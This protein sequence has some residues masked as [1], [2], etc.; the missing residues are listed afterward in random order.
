MSHPH[1][2]E[3][4]HV[5]FKTHLDVGFTDYARNVVERYFTDYIPRAVTLARE[6]REAQ[7]PRRF[8][9]TTGSWLIYEYLEQAKQD[10]RREME[11]AILE[12]DITWH[13]MPFTVHSENMDPALF[14][15]G[16]SLSSELDRRFGKKTIAAKM[17]DVPGHTRAIVPLLAEAGVRFL[18]I[19][20]NA[21]STPPDVPPVF[22]WQAPSGAEIAVMY[23][24]GSYGDLMTLPDLPDAIAFAHTNDNLGP[25]SKEELE[26]AFGKIQE[27]FKDASVQA[28]TLD[29]FAQSLETIWDR[30]PVIT[31]EIGDTWIHGVG[32]DPAKISRYRALLRLRRTWQEHGIPADKLHDFHRKLLLIPEHTWGMDVK[33]YL[34]DWENYTNAEFLAVRSQENY[35]TIEASWQEQRD[36][37]HAALDGLND[38]NL[39][40]E[41]EAALS[42]VQP[43]RPDVAPFSPIE[44]LAAPQVTDHFIFTLDPQRGFINHLERTPYAEKS[45]PRQWASPDFPLA[46]F[47]YEAFSASD[48]QRFYRQYI[49]NK[50]QTSFWAKPDFTKPGMENAST[51]HK[52][53]YPTLTWAGMCQSPQSQKYLLRCTM[54]EESW[55]R[56]GAPRELTLEITFPRS[57]PVIEFRLQWFDKTACRIAEAL[58]FSFIP[59]VRQPRSWR[60][61]KLGEWISPLEVI[62]DGNCKL[63]AVGQG[64]R[65][66]EAKTCIE[67]ESLDAPLV[68]PGQPSLLDFNNRQPNLRGGM[69]FNLFNNVWGTNFPMWYE[70]DAMLR[71]RLRFKD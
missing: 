12:G 16:L 10:A 61:E 50:R 26:A 1:S 65:C 53:F 25:Q 69:H 44:N 22:R 60:M 58:W 47:R 46:L 64:V 24:K 41:A 55:Q 67:I 42:E 62:R 36:Y 32:T 34:W 5:I 66:Q 20:V 31:Q 35:R 40:S 3:R 21:A 56:Y 15:F 7:S 4:I 54:P 45:R 6:L 39:R 43:A 29:A 70:E 49:Q 28:S 30:L 71:F 57:E 48:Y 52:V 23:H 18:H 38:P 17:T 68:A 59:R 9:W 33:T 11:Q 14:R 13:A 19:G 8:I 37:L 27:Q 2:P 63:H 51:E